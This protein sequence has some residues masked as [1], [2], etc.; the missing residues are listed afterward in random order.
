MSGQNIASIRSS[1]MY[2]GP[3]ISIQQMIESWFAEHK[4][5]NMNYIRAYPIREPRLFII[6]LL[7]IIYIATS[8][9]LLEHKMVYKIFCS[10]FFLYRFINHSKQ[11]GHFTV[12]VNDKNNAVGCAMVRY[13]EK[14]VST[15]YLVCNYGY[16]NVIGQRVYESGRTASKCRIRDLIFK[17]LCVSV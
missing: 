11:I 5:A 13:R 3:N 14:G 9:Y 17:G 7:Y 6:K 10:N 12:M 1:R 2:K 8:Y 16:T 4:N 15:D